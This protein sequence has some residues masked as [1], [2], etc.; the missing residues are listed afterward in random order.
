M[1]RDSTNLWY[2]KI[3]QNI[4][5]DY[6][7]ELNVTI[8]KLL[9]FSLGYTQCR[10]FFIICILKKYTID[11]YFPLN[12]RNI[13]ICI[14]PYSIKTRKL[15]QFKMKINWKFPVCADFPSNHLGWIQMIGFCIYFRKMHKHIVFIDIRISHIRLTLL[16]Q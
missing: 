4:E 1:A 12:Y 9:T 11:I 13:C 6:S 7:F 8:R 5:N 2:S 14:F 15:Q 3:C 16:N 10:L